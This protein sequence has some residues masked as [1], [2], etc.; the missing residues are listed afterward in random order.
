MVLPDRAG[1]LMM[2]R[3]TFL[4]LTIANWN[5]FF[6]ECSLKTEHKLFYGV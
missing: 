2:K 5:C 3:V 4:E 6:D 1:Q